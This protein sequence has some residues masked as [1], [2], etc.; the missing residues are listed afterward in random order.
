M[1]ILK[2]SVLKAKLRQLSPLRPEQ[3]RVTRYTFAYEIFER[4][5]KLREHLSKFNSTTVDSLCSRRIDNLLVQLETLNSV[6][7]EF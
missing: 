5:V 4:Y 2:S 3:P 7:N 6:I 1:V